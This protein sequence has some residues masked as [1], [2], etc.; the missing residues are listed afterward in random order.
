MNV[1][2]SILCLSKN[3]VGLRFITVEAYASAFN[4]HVEKNNFSYIRS[5][6]KNV[7]K[8]DKITNGSGKAVRRSS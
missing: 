5:D 6:A 4:F 2:L 3:K 7:E 1:L 8:L